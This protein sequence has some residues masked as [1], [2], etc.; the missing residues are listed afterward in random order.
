MAQKTPLLDWRVG[1][2]RHASCS[3]PW[4][5]IVLDAAAGQVIEHL[6]TDLRNAGAQRTLRSTTDSSSK[7]RRVGRTQRPEFGIAPLSPQ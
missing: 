5:Q 1:H 3:A 4:Q 6:K 7:Y 2:D